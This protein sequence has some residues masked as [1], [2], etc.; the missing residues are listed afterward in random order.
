MI[1]KIIK[2]HPQLVEKNLLDKL[3]SID[4]DFKFD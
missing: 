4:P 2:N 3:N 1:K